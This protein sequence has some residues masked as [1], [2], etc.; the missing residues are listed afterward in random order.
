LKENGHF[1]SCAPFGGETATYTVHLSL[2]GKLVVDFLFLVIERLSLGAFALFF[3]RL[4]DGR[5]VRRTDGFS[6]AET[7]PV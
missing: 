4:M 6:I 1:R 5:T 2:I 7:R 3:S